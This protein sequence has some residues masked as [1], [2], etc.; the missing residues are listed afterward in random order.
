MSKNLDNC[1]FTINN[2]TS[3]DIARIQY[4]YAEGLIKYYVYGEEVG[5]KGTPHLQGYIEF[6]KKIKFNTVR[7]KILPRAHIEPR[8]GTQEQAIV[9]CKKDG[10]V[11]EVGTKSAQGSRTD[12]DTLKQYI[13]EGHDLEEVMSEFPEFYLKYHSAITSWIGAVQLRRGIIQVTQEFEDIKWE[14]WQVLLLEI[15]KHRPDPRKIIWYF[16]KEGGKG[17][18]TISRYLMCT[19]NAFIVTGGSKVD[20]LYAY[21]GER[22]VILD[23]SRDCQD[24][25]YIYDVMEILKNGQYL[26]TKYVPQKRIYPKPHIVV[27]ANFEPDY[28]RFTDDRWNVIKL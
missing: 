9:Y 12:I 16:D 4:Q 7:A 25:Q 28:T 19:Q 18:S 3:A 5:E 2:W 17:K 20:I 10:I 24:R 1:V 6:S 27:F 21:R 8:R 26:S 22:I 13:E 11:T 23:L 14:P 15:L